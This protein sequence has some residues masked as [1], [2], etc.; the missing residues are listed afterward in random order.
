MPFTT[1][2]IVL[3]A[4]LSARR[5]AVLTPPQYFSSPTT[6]ALRPA[7]VLDLYLN[8]STLAVD[9]SVPLTLIN[10]LHPLI[11]QATAA[12]AR[13]RL[14]EGLYSVACSALGWKFAALVC[15]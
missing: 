1:Y 11:L 14:K 6:L 5:K 8:G 12:E 9:V 13:Q 4:V 3:T 10:P 2:S 15:G 7:D